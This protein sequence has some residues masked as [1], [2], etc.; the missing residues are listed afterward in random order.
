MKL[1]AL[2]E[3]D[4]EL[5]ADEDI[6]NAHDDGNETEKDEKKPTPRHFQAVITVCLK[7][8]FGRY[9]LLFLQGINL[10]KSFNLFP[11]LMGVDVRFLLNISYC[12]LFYITYTHIAV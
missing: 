2:G 1:E 9:I 5:Q 3:V 10:Q 12:G 4:E 11:F 8:V 7:L 6:E